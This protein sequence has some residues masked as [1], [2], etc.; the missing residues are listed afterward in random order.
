M[1]NL[2]KLFREVRRESASLAWEGTFRDYLDMVIKD[3]KLARLSHARIYD[4][5]QWSGIKENADGTRRYQLFEDQLFGAE[6]TLQR[7]VQIFHAASYVP[8]ERRR[9]FLLMGPP[10]SGKSTLVNLIK[11]GLERYSRAD[12]GT[13]YA[14]AGCPMQEEPLHLV[15]EDRREELQEAYGLHIEGDLCPRCRYNLRRQY[16]GD[17]SKVKVNRLTFAEPEG[18]GMGSFVATSPEGQDMARLVGSIDIDKLT[19]D[20]VEGAGKAF[21]LDGELEAANRGIMEFI[22][23]F[24]SDDT[25]LTVILGVTQEQVIKLGSFGSVYADETIIAHSNEAE[26]NTFVENQQTEALM[27]RLILMKVPYNLRVSEE[28]KIYRKLLSDDHPSNV[29]MSPLTLPVIASMA[30]ISRLEEGKGVAGLPKVS[31][32]DKAEMYDGKAMPPYSR[33]DVIALQDESIREGMFGLSPRFIVNRLANGMARERECLTPLEAL[34][35][36][37][38]GLEERAGL[39][40]EEQ[41]RLP[42]L[43]PEVIKSYRN[44]AIVQVQQAATERY[45]ELAQGHFESYINNAEALSTSQGGD[46]GSSLPVSDQLMRRTEGAINMR[47]SERAAFRQDIQRTYNALR[48]DGETPTYRD[49]PLLNA[50]IEKLLLPNPRELGQIL[51]PHQTSPDR[52]QQHNQILE[53]LQSTYGYCDKCAKDLVRSAFRTLQNQDVASIKKGKLVRH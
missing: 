13:L 45:P 7:L 6:R 25:F 47:D 36:L 24:R 4:M 29:H 11:K 32:V 31:L 41:E 9:I 38:E 21:R 15:P 18:I 26:Y 37:A 2:Q 27:D 3:P 48:S 51:D 30:V 19:E 28:M 16:R 44:L 33:D 1:V 23:I 5:L 52:L 17:I 42:N 43:L 14:I 40:A 35:G 50:A 8:E 22:Q 20:R 46:S 10:G 53:R 12:E 49:F 39:S 34:Q